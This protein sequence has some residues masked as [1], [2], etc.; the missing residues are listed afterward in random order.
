LERAP[1]LRSSPIIAVLD[2]SCVRTALDRQLKTGTPPASLWSVRDGT[3]RLFIEKDTLYETWARLPRFAEQLGVPVADLRRMFANDWL[4]HLSVVALPPALRE[5]D[6]RAGEVPDLDPDDYPT[7]AL[8][9]LLSPCILLTHNFKHFAP[10]GIREWS[11][12][13]DAVTAAVAVQIGQARFGAAVAIPGVPVWATGA[14][15][16]W[17]AERAGPIVWGGLALLFLAGILVYLHQPAERKGRIKTVTGEVGMFLLEEA[18]TA[19]ASVAQARQ[20]LD[21]YVVPARDPRLRQSAVLRE[22]AMAEDSMS[23]QQLYDVLELVGRPD[24]G[25]LRRFL[26]GYKGTV[27]V[28]RR[29]GSFVLG[30]RYRVTSGLDSS[31]GGS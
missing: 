10:L 3:I 26:H 11:Q 2:T 8:A 25:S 22:L 19:A 9:T 14:G 17:A 13:V 20:L 16:K 31:G 6:P 28:E 27:F 24:V 29:R 15:I 1:E 12:G 18:T 4:P 21:S 30:A 23:A 7:A 5:L